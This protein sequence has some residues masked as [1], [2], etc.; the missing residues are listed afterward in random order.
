[1]GRAI[2]DDKYVYKFMRKCMINNISNAE[3]F[4]VSFTSIFVCIV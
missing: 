3:V 4:A 2:F 1:M